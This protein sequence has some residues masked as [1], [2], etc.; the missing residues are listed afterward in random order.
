[1]CRHL[2]PRSI[3][4]WW[5]SREWLLPLF[6]SSTRWAPFGRPPTLSCRLGVLIWL[7]QVYMLGW[8]CIPVS[9]ELLC[10][11][12]VLFPESWQCLSCPFVDGQWTPWSSVQFHPHSTGEFLGHGVVSLL[13]SRRLASGGRPYPRSPFGPLSDM[14][15]R[16]SPS[17]REQQLPVAWIVLRQSWSVCGRSHYIPCTAVLCPVVCVSGIWCSLPSVVV[18]GVWLLPLSVTVLACWSLAILWSEHSLSSTLW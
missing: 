13:L 17:L 2:W 14:W 4:A 12:S 16:S 3:V 15:S 10:P 11:F 18:P 7:F 1:M 9:L 5:I 6:P 8:T